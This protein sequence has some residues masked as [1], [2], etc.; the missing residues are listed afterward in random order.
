[1]SLLRSPSPLIVAVFIGLS[2]SSALSQTAP[3]ELNAYYSKNGDT[4]KVLIQTAENPTKAVEER[5]KSFTQLYV[6][7][8]RAALDTA[9]K[10]S[11]DDDLTM[12]VDGVTFL[13]SIVVMMNHGPSLDTHDHSGDQSIVKAVTA[14]RKSSVDSR[15]PVREVAAASLSS[16]NDEPTLKEL[17]KSVRDRKVTDVEALRYITLASPSVGADYVAGFLDEGTT[18]ARSEAI[19]YLSSAAQYRTQ[20]KGYLLNDKAPVE[21]RSAAAKGLA[22]NDPAFGSYAP[23]IVADPKLPTA[24]FDGLVSEM[25]TNLSDGVVKNVLSK[26]LDSPLDRKKIDTLSKS[27]NRYEA[28]RPDIDIAPLQGSLKRLNPT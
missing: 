17:Q 4:I 16:L 8:P 2:S 10:L 11:T 5:R 15:Q 28:I 7:Y 26:A 14:L 13:S 21:V 20:I 19:S 27:L 1:M 24:V 22:R 6:A 3:D 9:I 23:A 18:K 12:A 25:G